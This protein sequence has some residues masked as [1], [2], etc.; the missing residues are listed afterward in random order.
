MTSNIEDDDIKD[1]NNPL[2][3]DVLSLVER[4]RN[5]RY[6]LMFNFNHMFTA[7]VKQAENEEV[8]KIE[9]K[10]KN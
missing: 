7:L 10:M 6:H 9:N 2:Y 4:D 8:I 5:I 1:K 3:K